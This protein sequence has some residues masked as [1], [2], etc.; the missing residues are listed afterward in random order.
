[1]TSALFLKEPQQ[2]SSTEL[3]HGNSNMEPQ[4]KNQTS[5]V[6]GIFFQ[7]YVTEKEE[8]AFAFLKICGVKDS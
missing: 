7:A 4:T 6:N 3:K 8:M 1:M 2:D 5:E